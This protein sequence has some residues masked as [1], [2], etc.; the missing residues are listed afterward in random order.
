MADQPSWRQGFDALEQQLSPRIEALVQSEQFAVVVGLAARV[1]R[2]IEGEMARSTRRV[3][4][5]LNLPAGTDVSRI[6][7]EIGQLRVQVRELSNELDEARAELATRPPAPVSAITRKA[8]ARKRAAKKA[9][10]A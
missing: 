4:H 10:A 9:G 5:R 6:L 8:P 1:Q 2:V 3:L 7:N